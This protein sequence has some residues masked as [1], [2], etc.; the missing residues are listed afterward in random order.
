MAEDERKEGPM[1]ARLALAGALAVTAAWLA[2]GSAAAQEATSAVGP[3]AT[4][5]VAPRSPEELAVIVAVASPVAEL[6]SVD[7]AA[8]LPRGKPADAETAAAITNAARE[9]AGCLN[10]ADYPRLLALMTERSVRGVV[11]QWGA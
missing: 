11:E 5:Q 2:A 7:T 1:S 6:D 8:G 10:A 4:C 9:F 3:P